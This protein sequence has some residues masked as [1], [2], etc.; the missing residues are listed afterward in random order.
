MDHRQQ[1]A[2]D[3]IDR[4]AVDFLIAIKAHAPDTEMVRQAEH[5][6]GALT[7]SVKTAIV[8]DHA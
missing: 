4:A 2:I 8:N 6:L 1:R 3:A 7:D 5:A